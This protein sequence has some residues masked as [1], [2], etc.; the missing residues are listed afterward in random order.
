MA[1]SQCENIPFNL[2]MIETEHLM[3]LGV[4]IMQTNI[5]LSIII[6]VMLNY[7]K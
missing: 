1:T 5:S 3:Q 7:Y 4:V 6:H 2:K